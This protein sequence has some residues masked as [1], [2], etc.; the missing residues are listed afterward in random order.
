SALAPQKRPPPLRQR[1]NKV[2]D[3]RR[4]VGCVGSRGIELH[5]W[6][7]STLLHVPLRARCADGGEITAGPG[8]PTIWP[9]LWRMT[10]PRARKDGRGSPG[11]TRGESAG[12]AAARPHQHPP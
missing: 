5:A 12:R 1:I 6:P 10:E 7:L 8:D 11:R 3:E 4:G 9:V 2:A